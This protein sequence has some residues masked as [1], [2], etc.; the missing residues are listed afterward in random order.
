MDLDEALDQFIDE[1]RLYRMEGRQG[2]E[3]FAKICRVLGYK[4]FSSYGQMAGG[5][6]LGDILT[7]LEDNS[8]ALEAILEW[9]KERNTP[10]WLDS[11]KE[12]ITSQPLAADQ[13]PD[14]VCPDCGEE[15][16]PEAVV[17]EACDNCGHVFV[18]EAPVDDTWNASEG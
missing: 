4:D 11:V 15:I 3:N 1:N 10:E 6:C 14:G 2:V 12:C 18:L 17:G 9:I 13:Y 8:G 16:N 7:F 5:A